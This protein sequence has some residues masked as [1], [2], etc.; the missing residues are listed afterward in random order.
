MTHAVVALALPGVVAFDLSTAAQVFGHPEEEEYSF[1]VV[2]SDGRQVPSSTGFQI[3]GVGN[4]SSLRQADTIVIPGYSPHT[5]PSDDV[6]EALRSA[7]SRGTRVVSIC[8]GAFALAPTGLLDGLSATTHWQDAEELRAAYPA[9]DVTPD[10][11]YIDHGHVASS[12]GVAAGIDLCLHLVRRD[13]GAAT[14]N[15]IARRM[16]V[17]PHRAG[18]QAQYVA[19]AARPRHPENRLAELTTWVVAHLDRPVG[20]ADL[21]R[22]AHLSERQLARRF[23]AETGQSPLQW[24]LHQRVLAAMDLLETTGLP[25]EAIATRTG[26]GTASTL[27]RHFLRHVGTTPSAYRKTFRGPE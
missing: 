22:H 14:A 9:V 1:E 10:V 3:A 2:T 12:A 5:T 18:G 17:P 25:L 15:R 11:L 21:A 13:H 23:V 26:L 24:L 16:V 27:R 20:V 6:L 4:P 7:H 8:T 19:P